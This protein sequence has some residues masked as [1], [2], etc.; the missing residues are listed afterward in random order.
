MNPL[1]NRIR[2][3]FREVNPLT[4]DLKYLDVLAEL[5]IAV[6]SWDLLCFSELYFEKSVCV[7]KKEVGD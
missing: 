3:T 4:V 2:F 5:L 6:T 1:R 7:R